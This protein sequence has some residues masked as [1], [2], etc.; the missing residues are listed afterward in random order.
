MRPFEMVVN[1]GGNDSIAM[2]TVENAHISA[3]FLTCFELQARFFESGISRFSLKNPV[4]R[5]S[6]LEVFFL[7]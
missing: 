7:A 6:F 2:P 1:V 5:D 4:K 3:F